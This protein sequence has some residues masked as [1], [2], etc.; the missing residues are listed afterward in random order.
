MFCNNCQGQNAYWCS[1]KIVQ[2]PA[3]NQPKPQNDK[4]DVVVV[5]LLSKLY[6]SHTQCNVSSIYL[7]QI[8]AC[9]VDVQ[10]I[11]KKVRRNKKIYTK[12]KSEKISGAESASVINLKMELLVKIVNDFKL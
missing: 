6:R 3:Q 8:F 9:R 10:L 5:S 7:E 1:S 11:F 4:T 12:C 2:R